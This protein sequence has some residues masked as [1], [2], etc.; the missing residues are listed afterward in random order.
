MSSGAFVSPDTVPDDHLSS[1]ECHRIAEAAARLPGDYR[2]Q[3]GPGDGSFA[4]CSAVPGPE[5]GGP[6][7][8]FC[9]FGSTIMLLTKQGEGAKTVVPS[10]SLQEAIDAMEAAAGGDS[11]GMPPSLH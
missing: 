9:R 11:G 8:S 4:W 10:S 7:F 5:C 3:V 2:I 1:A 6:T